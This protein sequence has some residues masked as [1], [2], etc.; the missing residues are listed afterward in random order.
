VTCRRHFTERAVRLYL[1]PTS[2]SGPPSRA[3]VS[4]ATA[5]RPRA[6]PPL[7]AS[8][9]SDADCVLV[10]SEIEDELP[11]TY[12]CCPGCT[13]RAANRGWLARFENACESAPPPMCPPIGCPV[14][15]LRAQ[16]FS[17]RG[18]FDR[19]S[20][21]TASTSTRSVRIRPSVRPVLFVPSSAH[22]ATAQLLRPSRY[23]DASITS[24]ESPH[25]SCGH[26]REPTHPPRHQCQPSDPAGISDRMLP[27][28]AIGCARNT[29]LSTAVLG[30]AS[31]KRHACGD[32]YLER[33]DRAA[34][35]WA[36]RCGSAPVLGCLVRAAS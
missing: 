23:A 14:P 26:A 22:T 9:A 13:E 7:D 29:Q 4:S 3:A 36:L 8:C 11:R 16:W 21:R 6:F 35:V 12:A 20:S 28:R 32:G 5:T 18:I 24:T 31:C 34:V 2:P 17:A 15:I 19:S 33:R 25:D 30:F 1:A 27:E 10:G